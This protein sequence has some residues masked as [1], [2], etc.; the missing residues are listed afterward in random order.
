ML[1]SPAFPPNGRIPET[2]TCKGRDINPPLDISGV[3]RETMS[4]VLVMDDPDAPSGTWDHWVVFDIDPNVRSIGE[5][6]QPPPGVAGTGSGGELSYQGPCPPSGVHRYVFTLYALNRKLSLP[7][8]SSKQ[9]V[10]NALNGQ[11]IGRAEL[12][13]R[14]GEE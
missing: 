8:G 2:Y 13:G 4:L 12:I 3:P 11:V 10:L 14:Y 7:E 1:T 5:D 6:S 9:A